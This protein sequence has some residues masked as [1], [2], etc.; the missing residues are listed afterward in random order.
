MSSR[1]LFGS[2]F[3]N[4]ARSVVVPGIAALL[5]APF[6]P[7][8]LRAQEQ[9]A[10][11]S[12]YRFH[13]VVIG[14]GGGFIP[15][16]VFS[17]TE[18]GLVYARTDIG[19]AY[20][21]DPE[22]GRWIPLLDWIGFPDWNLSGVESIAIDPV[23]PERVYLAV[24]T[25]T[26]EYATENGAIIFPPVPA[27]YTR[28]STVAEMVDHTVGRV[29]DLF[30]IDAGLVPRWTGQQSKNRQRSTDTCMRPGSHVG[31]AKP[32]LSSD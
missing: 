7:S 22:A 1:T 18:P 17:T 12:P 2:S 6:N 16:I 3:P 21:F 14:G 23:D 20:R 19:G 25:Y 10:G 5:L 27:F 9:Q 24:G 29:L 32:V 11:F 26:N 31:E 8:T 15:G 28:P 30:G 13:N 4:F